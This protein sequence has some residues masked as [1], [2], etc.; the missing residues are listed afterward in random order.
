MADLSK[1]VPV[2][3]PGSPAVGE[4]VG[5]VAGDETGESIEVNTPSGT[6]IS[7]GDSG[8]GA[9]ALQPDGS[10]KS[11][12]RPSETAAHKVGSVQYRRRKT[13][14]EFYREKVTQRTIIR[15]FCEDPGFSKRAL[16]FHGLFSGFI[17]MSIL[18]FILQTENG[19]GLQAEGNLTPEQFNILEAIFTTVF[20]IDIGV[21]FAVADVKCCFG[22]ADFQE[23]TP[24]ALDVL[25]WLDILSVLPYPLELIADAAGL[26][27]FTALLNFFNLFRICRIFKISRQFDGTKVLL[28]TLN[29]SYEA[30]VIQLL[31]LFT[32]CLTLGFVL[33]LFEPCYGNNVNAR[34]NSCEFPD[35]MQS[36]YFLLIT[37][38]TVGYGDQIPVSTWGKALAVIVAIIGSFYM[39]MPLAII[40]TKFEEAYQ[41]RELWKLQ[42]REGRE[43]QQRVRSHM[44]NSAPAERNARMN[45][46]GL[47]IFSNL[48]VLKSGKVSSH[49]GTSFILVSLKKMLARY[50][51]DMKKCFHVELPKDVETSKKKKISFRNST[52]KLTQTLKGSVLPLGKVNL[53]H[54]KKKGEDYNMQTFKFE[55]RAK[56]ENKLSDQLWL[57]FEVP[58]S[59]R[60]ASTFNYVKMFVIFL[61]LLLLTFQSQSTYNDYGEDR[62]L[63]KQIINSYC[64]KLKDTPEVRENNKA[65]FEHTY[66]GLDGID[67]VYPGCRGLTHLTFSQCGFPNKNAFMTCA[68]ENETTSKNV[69][70][71]EY[72]YQ[73]LKLIPICEREQCNNNIPGA[74][75]HSELWLALEIVFAVL[76]FVEMVIRIA[77]MRTPKHFF[78]NKTNILDIVTALVCIIEVIVIPATWGESK[79]EI[80]G[81]GP[82]SDPAAVRISRIAVF[83]RFI[84]MQRHFVGLKVIIKTVKKVYKKLLIPLMFFFIFV[85]LFAGMFYTFERGDLYKCKDDSLLVEECVKCTKEAN[86]LLNGSCK[87]RLLGNFD[88]TTFLNPAVENMA[89]CV[90]TMLITM[91]TVGYG[92]KYP[93]TFGG[94]VTAI[95]AAIFG[96]FYLSMPLTIV[97]NSFY[98]IFVHEWAAV[99]TRRKTRT[100]LNFVTNKR[101]KAY[102]GKFSMRLVVKLK[103]WARKATRRLRIGELTNAEKSIAQ[104]YLKICQKVM[105]ARLSEIDYKAV[106]VPEAILLTEFEAAHTEMIAIVSDHLMTMH[107]KW[108]H[109]TERTIYNGNLT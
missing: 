11:G 57:L 59:S 63:C 73:S 75:D 40:G 47:K 97:G 6:S 64:N 81:N 98:E 58:N 94:Q 52:K 48:R 90:W 68:P 36:T 28:V 83:L 60:N 106:D 21:R 67:G 104:R 66:T 107:S 80:W 84:S 102:A 72:F 51:E 50:C 29:R 105:R 55:Q 16:I 44:D 25:F 53:E 38:T 23:G 18:C 70:D 99:K 62:R 4:V 87:L 37:I 1:I 86:N 92:G 22:R 9:K 56:L 33:F 45:R 39:A 79:F 82:F 100:S 95:C 2:S 32:M 27:D 93:Y 54:L 8:A 34:D 69:F 10:K 71:D 61:S 12:P 77:L 89:D 78:S 13:S 31:F 35:L 103:Q 14:N 88:S 96:S 85:L 74:A 76:F 101:K 24:M 49:G 20:I 26:G 41:E 3:A 42:R 109:P 108:I 30:I 46:L 19:A 43:L 91:T 15:D 7:D 65:C 5:E 17:L